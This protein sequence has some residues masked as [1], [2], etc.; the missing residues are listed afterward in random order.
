MLALPLLLPRCS[1]SFSYSFP[2]SLSACLSLS[3]FLR[4]TRTANFNTLAEKRAG[5]LQ[6]TERKLDKLCYLKAQNATQCSSGQGVAVA[7]VQEEGKRGQQAAGK[8]TANKPIKFIT[9]AFFK[10]LAVNTWHNTMLHKAVYVCL[11]ALCV[12]TF[13]VCVCVCV[14]A[15]HLASGFGTPLLVRP[16]SCCKSLTK[17]LKSEACNRFVKEINKYHVMLRVQAPALPA[18]STAGEPLRKKA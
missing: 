14:M 8:V 1:Q 4:N 18:C 11:C 15:R 13:Y 9:F 5:K 10:C 3:L 6:K 12:C 2:P 16:Q 17:C 7:V